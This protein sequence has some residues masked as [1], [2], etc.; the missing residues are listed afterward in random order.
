[1]VDGQRFIVRG[2]NRNPQ[3]NRPHRAQIG[4]DVF[5][6]FPVPTCGSLDE[7]AIPLKYN[8]RKASE[9]EA[10]ISGQTVPIVMRGT[11]LYSGLTGTILGGAPIFAAT[12]G[13]MTAQNNAS[14]SL[15]QVGIALGGTGADGSALIRLAIA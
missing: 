1:M 4:G 5:A 14:S 13:A 9:L 10:C 11:F 3:R 7:N 8:P 6:H 2:L 15:T 12:S